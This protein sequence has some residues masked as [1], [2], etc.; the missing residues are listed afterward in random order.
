M[1]KL[2]ENTTGSSCGAADSDRSSDPPFVWQLP[3]M[4]LKVLE[5]AT[6]IEPATCGLRNSQIPTSDNLSPQET[7]RPDA[8][9]MGLDRAELSCPGSSVVAG[10]F[11][12]STDLDPVDAGG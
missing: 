1:S 10:R 11:Q 9:D 2:P 4:P 5:P 12:S 7:T 3:D 6:G 8:P